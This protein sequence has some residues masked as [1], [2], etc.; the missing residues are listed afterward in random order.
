MAA[1][2]RLPRWLWPVGLAAVLVGGGV[3]A[4]GLLAETGP[5]F[6]NFRIPSASMEPTL[7]TGEQFIARTSDFLPIQRGAIYLVRKRSAVHAYRV[8]G[9][10][11]DIVE[12]K[13]DGVSLNKKAA[14]Y[15]DKD[16]AGLTG[17]CHLPSAQVRRETLPSGESHAILVCGGGFGQDMPAIKIPADQYF[18]LGDNRANA[19]DS[20]FTGGFGLGFVPE[21]DFVGKAERI[22]ISSDSARIGKEID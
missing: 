16:I 20:R 19:A 18:L 5:S 15:D 13:S 3:L 22:F 7:R 14:A 10:P 6:K 21:G 4:S 11:G 9:L 12:I 2:G 17:T 8:I 1:P